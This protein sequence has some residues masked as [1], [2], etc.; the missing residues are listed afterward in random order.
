[1]PSRRAKPAAEPFEQTIDRLPIPRLG[2][3]HRGVS[4]IML[5]GLGDPGVTCEWSAVGT[6]D[7]WS[8]VV[9]SPGDYG[10]YPTWQLTI[11]GGMIVTTNGRAT[12]QRPKVHFSGSVTPVAVAV[13]A[14]VAAMLPKGCLVESSTKEDQWW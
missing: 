14:F 3:I 13:L 12:Y 11:T 2:R 10:I 7:E 8:A 4:S 1:M 6:D 9:R 5:A